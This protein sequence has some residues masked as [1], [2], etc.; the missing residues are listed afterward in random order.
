MR[1]AKARV[2]S[3]RGWRASWSEAD[4]RIWMP[5]GVKIDLALDVVKMAPTEKGEVKS[6]E[7]VGVARIYPSRFK[8]R[9]G[10]GFGVSIFGRFVL[11]YYPQA[12]RIEEKVIRKCLRQMR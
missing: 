9:K 6:G 10:R 11:D 5:I 12:D 1:N 7:R 8:M 4:R 2:K 3:G